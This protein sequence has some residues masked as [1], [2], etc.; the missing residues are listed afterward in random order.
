[1]RQFQLD[2]ILLPISLHLTVRNQQINLLENAPY[3]APSLPS[4]AM[5]SSVWRKKG[6]FPR[7]AYPI[8]KFLSKRRRGTGRH[9]GVRMPAPLSSRTSSTVTAPLPMRPLASPP[10]LQTKFLGSFP[11]FLI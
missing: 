7:P 8:G 10:F 5:P 9:Y 2:I 3:L 1:M 6:R 4:Q 11:P